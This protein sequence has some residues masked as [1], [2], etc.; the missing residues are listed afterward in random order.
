MG[1]YSPFKAEEMEAQKVAWGLSR[2][3]GGFGMR[4]QWSLLPRSHTLHCL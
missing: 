1:G 4:A 2:A 3:S